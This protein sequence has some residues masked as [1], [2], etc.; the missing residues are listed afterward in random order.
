MTNYLRGMVVL[1][2]LAS[3]LALS[4]QT[5]A[6]TPAQAPGPAAAPA[7]A[8]PTAD[9]IVGKYLDAIGGEAVIRQVKSLSI[10]TS[11]QVMGNE[12]LGTVVVVD[13]VGYKSEMEINGG[14]IVQCFNANGGW[15]INPMAGAPDPTAMSDDQYKMGKDQIY[16]GGPLVH[17]AAKGSK[18]ELLASD[19]D[20]YTIKLTTRDNV[21]TTYLID[22][23]TYLIKSTKRTG[24]IQGQAV[25]ITTNY[26]DYRKTDAGY[27]L[28]YAMDVDFGGQFQLNISVKKVDV[29]LTIDPAIFDMPKPSTQPVAPS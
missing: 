20:A 8:G 23:K 2:A 21:E 29:N 9:E 10:E 24:Q 28:P 4:A 15:Q 14:K 17:Y 12:V 6:Q 27:L 19:P 25:D 5:P 13:G 22:A 7:Q 11:A 18:V 26:S 16:V 1:S 3:G